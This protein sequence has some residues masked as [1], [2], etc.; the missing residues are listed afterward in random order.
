[1]WNKTVN[2]KQES[3]SINILIG[4][5]FHYVLKKKDILIGQ[6]LV[7]LLKNYLLP[8]PRSQSASI[9]CH[10]GPQLLFFVFGC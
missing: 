1:M 7:F 8:N 9:F 4:H 5:N 6:S 3:Q 2:A 10:L